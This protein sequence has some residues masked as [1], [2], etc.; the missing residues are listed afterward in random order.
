MNL[1]ENK[2]LENFEISDNKELVDYLLCICDDVISK[3]YN[4]KEF[5]LLGKGEKYNKYKVQK[6]NDE[7][8]VPI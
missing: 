2:R 8:D 7:F 5:E 3:E 4:F 1:N 6:L